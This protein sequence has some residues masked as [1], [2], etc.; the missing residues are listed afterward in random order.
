MVY[1]SIVAALKDVEFPT[2]KRS[3]IRRI[4]DREVE[5][6][7]GKTMTMREILRAC[8]HEDYESERDV[9][10]CPGVVS[11]VRRTA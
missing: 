10:A 8:E 4:G 2:T 5:L 11:K 1:K 9:F 6:L 7:A 3:L